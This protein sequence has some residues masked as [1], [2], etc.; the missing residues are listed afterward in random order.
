M[1]MFITISSM[2]ELS[3][4]SEKASEQEIQK[5][6][7]AMAE[8]QRKKLLELLDQRNSKAYLSYSK[9]ITEDHLFY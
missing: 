5:E 6:K 8:K 4:F 7:E 2:T 3:Q 9:K 1:I